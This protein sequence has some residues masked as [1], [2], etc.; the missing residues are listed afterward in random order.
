M[1][2]SP[3][4]H[5]LALCLLHQRLCYTK[6]S[7]ALYLPLASRAHPLKTLGLSCSALQ[8]VSLQ[9]GGNID[10]L[11]SVILT[12]ILPHHKIETELW[13]KFTVFT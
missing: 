10:I 6:W 11:D 12:H 7:P 5:H 8:R 3:P 1:L 13:A 9:N 2:L 4:V